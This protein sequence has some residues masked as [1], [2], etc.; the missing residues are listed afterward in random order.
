MAK[1]RIVLSKKN[2]KSLLKSKEMKNFLEQQA[3]EIKNK[4]GQGYGSDT[5]VGKNRLNVA[6][7]PI[8]QE[9]A[10]DCYENNTLIKALK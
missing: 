4:A 1:T 10:Q 7:Y 5:H 2:V 6:I 8:T 3:S 9:A